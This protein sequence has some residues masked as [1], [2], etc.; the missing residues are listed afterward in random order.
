M[1]KLFLIWVLI[2]LG[3][4]KP[5]EINLAANEWI[6]YAPLFYLNEIG[7]LK[8]LN[9]RLITTVSLAE[10]VNLYKSGFVCGFAS[11]NYEYLPLKKELTQIALFDKSFGADM[12]MSNKTIDEIKNSKIYA[13]LEIDS[14]NSLLL[15]SFLKEHKISPKNVIKIDNDQELLS[16]REFDFNKTNLVV[17][18]AP[19]DVLFKKKGFKVIASTK[20]DKNLLVIDALYIRNEIANEERFNK[21]KYEI[22][23]AIDFIK[24]EPKKVYEIIKN[25]YKDYSFDDF[26][27]ALNNIKWY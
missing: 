19:Y 7:V 17:T 15:D 4:S 11:T 9:I 10:S 26:K 1:K 6:G 24:K 22:K 20:S 13:Y 23:K 5:K 21:L 16:K 18:Y 12:I 3:C 25:Y 14:V 8:K 27:E 2:F